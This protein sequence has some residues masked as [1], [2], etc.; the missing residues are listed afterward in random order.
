[1]KVLEVLWPLLYFASAVM[2]R[3]VFSE[4]VVGGFRQG[5]LVATRVPSSNAPVTNVLSND[6]ICNTNHIQPVS[7]TVLN[8]KA[9][10]DITAIFHRTSAGYT[11]HDPASPLDPVNKGPVIA[12]LARTLNATQPHVTGLQW[13]KIWQDGYDPKTGQW[14]SDRLYQNDGKATFTVPS[15]LLSGQY[16]LR[17]EVISLLNANK[18]PGA[19]FYM[20]CSQINVVSGYKYVPAGVKFPGAYKPSD[21]G[22]VTDIFNVKTYTPPGPGVFVCPKR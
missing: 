21:S 9:G 7:Q 14:G 11:G 5:P 19:E 10:T 6:L 8:V 2:G 3:T 20:S 12:Y 15:C 13:F 1:M 22:I 17:V 4:L 16:F 18:Y